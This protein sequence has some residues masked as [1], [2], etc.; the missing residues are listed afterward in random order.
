MMLN[1]RDC[2][3]CEDTLANRVE[4]GVT[5]K[6]GRTYCVAGAPNDV[7]YK[8]NTLIPGISMRYLPKYVAVW[9]KW[10]RFDCRYRRYSTLQSRRPISLSRLWRLRTH[11]TDQIRGRWLNSAKKMAAVPISNTI[12]PRSFRL[13]FRKRRMVSIILLFF[14]RAWDILILSCLNNRVLSFSLQSCSM[15]PRI[16]LQPSPT[17][18]PGCAVVNSLRF[19]SIAIILSLWWS[20]KQGNFFHWHTFWG[21]V[22]FKH[23]G[24]PRIPR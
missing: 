8:N 16:T 21:L 5:K 20:V 3:Y 15:V 18:V 1:S 9:P 23:L 6:R 12:V 17:Q 24:K 22:H 7:R 2:E 14:S 13:T 10:T 11:T 4:K 19:Y